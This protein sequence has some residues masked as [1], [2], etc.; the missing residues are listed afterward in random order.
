MYPYTSS[1]HSSAS[2]TYSHTSTSTATADVA[3]RLELV[4]YL[5]NLVAYVATSSKDFG[6]GLWDVKNPSIYRLALSLVSTQHKECEIP[7]ST[8]LV[9]LVFISRAL[10]RVEVTRDGYVCERILLSAVMLAQKT[11]NDTQWPIAVWVEKS[12]HMFRVE[13]LK[14]ME[15]DFL[16][17]I[18]WDLRYTETQLGLHWDALARSQG[19]YW[20]CA[21]PSTASFRQDTRRPTIER[22]YMRPPS[23]SHSTSSSPS[24]SPLFTPDATCLWPSTS[25]TKIPTA[26]SGAKHSNRP[27][28][29]NFQEGLL[30]PAP[31]YPMLRSQPLP[32]IRQVLPEHFPR[33]SPPSFAPQSTPSPEVYVL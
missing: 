7:T 3:L 30:L 25:H 10:G 16:Y 24:Q 33:L 6:P 15:L 20:H 23:L 18:D 5:V 11:V 28:F 27:R 8:F 2:S 21:L 9:A 13:D 32:S 29:N 22:G 19:G 4:H 31:R 12:A 14:R 26:H 17:L 1:S